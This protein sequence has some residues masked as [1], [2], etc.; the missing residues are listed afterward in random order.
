M[1]LTHK[2]NL[3][4]NVV[5]WCYL[6]LQRWRFSALIK[7]TKSLKVFGVSSSWSASNVH[8]LCSSLEPPIS[9][10]A[11]RLTFSSR[12]AMLQHWWSRAQHVVISAPRNCYECRDMW[13]CVQGP[14]KY[15]SKKQKWSFTYY[16]KKLAYLFYLTC[17]IH[18]QNTCT[19]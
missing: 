14:P 1:Y 17:Q 9:S 4:Y 5:R 10:P 2:Y 6:A 19:I 12:S 3:A 18:P 7:P 13:F 8:F 16:K 11:L 15:I